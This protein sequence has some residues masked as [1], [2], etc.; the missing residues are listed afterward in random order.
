M[1]TFAL[2]EPSPLVIAAFCLLAWVIA[3]A[4]VIAV[5][6]WIFDAEKGDDK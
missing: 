5:A 3:R 6:S 4:V 2:S 1:Q